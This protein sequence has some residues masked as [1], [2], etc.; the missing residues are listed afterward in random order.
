MAKKSIFISFDYENDKHYKFLLTAL[1]ANPRF[2]I[3]FNDKSA[4][5]IKSSEIPVVK[6][7]L[8]RKINEA[9]YTLCIIGKYA[10]TRHKDYL[11][12]GKKNWINFEIAQSKKNG[13]KLI[14]I[15]IDNS[16]ESPDEI[17]NSGASWARSFTEDSIT[18][19]LDEA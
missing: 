14:A 7:G 8:T 11:E 6:A 1:S 3:S 18:K 9:R 17:L 12:I 13:N 19:A 2:E 5:E 15:K 4:S 10:N 16:Y